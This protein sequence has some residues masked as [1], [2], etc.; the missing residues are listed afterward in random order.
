MKTGRYRLGGNRT[1]A[2]NWTDAQRLSREKCLPA[3]WD[4]G[5]VHDSKP[6]Y[7][8]EAGLYEQ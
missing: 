6:R 5:H 4:Q 1:G 8:P 7:A 2:R 3:P